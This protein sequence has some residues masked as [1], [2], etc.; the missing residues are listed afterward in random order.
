MDIS[1]WPHY[2]DARC[3]ILKT[4]NNQAFNSTFLNELY[5]KVTQ[6]LMRGC[7]TLQECSGK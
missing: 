1:E 5:L 2:D 6:E 7:F 4:D 3:I